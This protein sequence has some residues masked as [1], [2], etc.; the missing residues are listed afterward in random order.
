M[1]ARDVEILI[2]AGDDSDMD[3]LAEHVVDTPLDLE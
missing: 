2:R 3:S 1:A